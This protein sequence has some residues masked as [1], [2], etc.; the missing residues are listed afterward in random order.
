V[1]K[2]VFVIGAGANAEIGMPTGKT[3]KGTIAAMLN[4]EKA[5]SF[6]EYDQ[7]INN[8]LLDRASYF[9]GEAA[10]KYKSAAAIINQALPFAI[11]IDNL[12]DQHRGNRFVEHCGKLGIVR[13]IIEAERES[14]LFAYFEMDK[15]WDDP[16]TEAEIELHKEKDTQSFEFKKSWYPLFFQKISEGCNLEELKVRLR[17]MTF[18]IF[19]YDRCFE[20]FLVK[21]LGVSYCPEEDAIRIVK[22]LNIIHPYGTVG[23]MRFQG[24]S[25]S[26]AVVDFGAKAESYCGQLNDLAQGV[27][28]FTE[29]VSS[30]QG[31]MMASACVNADRVIFLGFAYHEQNLKLLYPKPIAPYSTPEAWTEAGFADEMPREVAFYG[32][33]W[34]I[35]DND[36][37]YITNMLMRMDG[38]MRNADISD[39]QCC[40]FF[41]EFWYRLSFK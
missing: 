2:T 11:S 26:P 33:G 16:H 32:I 8:A 21:A 35:S 37:N 5:D 34:H 15:S 29:S 14:D 38:R 12:I 22:G 30:E 25:N 1:E 10:H 20:Y 13:S 31:A 19:N 9:P 7:Y 36:R 18:V 3:L 41:N 6:N 17:D 28:T 39:K 40:D 24:P 27:K 23:L 4:F